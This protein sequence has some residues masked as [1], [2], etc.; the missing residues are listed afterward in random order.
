MSTHYSKRSPLFSVVFSA[1]ILALIISIASLFRGTTSILTM[2]LIPCVLALSFVFINVKDR[3]L[4]SVVCLLLTLILISTQSIFMLLYVILG[5]ILIKITQ[6]NQP[7]SLINML[8]YI[9]FVMVT[10]FVG[11]ILTQMVFMIPLHQI[12]LSI[13]KNSY[14]LYVFIVFVE[15]LIIS[16]VHLIFVKQIRNR[17]RFLKER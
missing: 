5:F 3:I 15:A 16:S 10:L 7:L 8:I 9:I 4:L 12:M 6:S 14:A 17:L 13:T 2:I 1:M 11:L